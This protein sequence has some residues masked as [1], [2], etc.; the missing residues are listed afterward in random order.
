MSK[1][2]TGTYD[3]ETTEHVHHTSVKFHSGLHATS[4]HE[5]MQHTRVYL[6]PQTN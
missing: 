2:Q 6:K 1:E 4:R 3:S 5:F